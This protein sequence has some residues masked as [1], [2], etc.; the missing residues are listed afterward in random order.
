MSL[1]K[2]ILSCALLVG[3]VLVSPTFAKESQ[4]DSF[5]Q[6]QLNHFENKVRPILVRRCNECHANGESEGG[7]SLR[8]RSA[9]IAGGDT[10]AA[11]V[12]GKPEA[13]L[14]VKAIHYDDV[15]E[16]P[17]ESKMP[18]EEIKILED[19]IRDSAPWPE[20]SGEHAAAAKESFDIEGR[21][22]AHW[23]W[24]PVV[25]PSLPDRVAGSAAVDWLLDRKLKAKGLESNGPTKRSSLLRRIS[26]DLTGLPPSPKQ[27]QQFAIDES[28]TKEQL[29][30]QLL[31]SPHFGE[32]WARHWMDLARY[33]ET[34]GHEFDYPINDAWQYRDYLIRAFNTDVPY[35]QFVTEHIAG[36]LVENPR[37]NPDS[38]FNESV[39]AT[40][41][42][43]LGEATHG[44]V[45][46]KEDEAKR[47]DN[48]IDVMCRSFIGL[49]VA[50]ARCHDH[51]FDAISTKDYYA[52]S[53]YLQSSR[54]QR[55]V[56]DKGRELEKA[57]NEVGKIREQIESAT[58]SLINKMAASENPDIANKLASID[59]PRLRVQPK[60]SWPNPTDEKADVE[61]PLRA[62]HWKTDGFA[63]ANSE[64]LSSD[65]N[66]MG[67]SGVAHSS[68]FEIKHKFI[69]IRLKSKKAFVQ[70]VVDGYRMH[71]FNAILFK[72]LIH[73]DVN[74]DDYQWLTIGKEL[75][76]HLGNR[77]WLEFED[78]GDGFFAIDRVVF[79]NREKPPQ[80]T[81]Q[82]FDP[83][84]FTELAQ[85]PHGN[86]I[87]SWILKHKL[88][89][90]FD[91]EKEA[92]QIRAL[93]QQVV[94]INEKLPATSRAITMTEGFPEDEF[95]FVR[96]NHKMTGE[97]A[98]RRF[99]SA[100]V[101]EDR[102]LDRD[103]GSGRLQL[104]R[105]LLDDSN[106]LASRVIVNRVWHHLFGRGIVRSVDNFGV[107]G[108]EP[109][110]PELLDHLADEFVKD[111]WSIKRLIRKLMLTEVYARSS[112][113]SSSASLDDPQN[114][115]LSRANVRRLQGEAIRD[116]ILVASGRLDR[117]MFGPSVP[118]HITPFM[119][120]RGRPGKSGEL[121]SNG[122]RSLYIATR[123]NFLSPMMLAFDTPIPF[124]AIGLR[125][126]S[127]VPAQALILMNDPLVL[128]QSERFAKRV[129]EQQKEI[130][131]RI[132]FVYLT[133]L[134]RKPDEGELQKSRS[135]IES[136]AKRLDLDID[137]EKV[138]AD[139]CHVVFNVKEFIWLN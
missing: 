41:F 88:E 1:F 86:E 17:P 14:L 13:S 131:K 61:F 30:D 118:I 134:S 79:S 9:M 105:K 55:E 28:I 92:G 43:F 39:L 32:R 120:G 99:L 136:H 48:Q 49:T 124:N 2:K 91:A 111:G 94:A 11:I 7:L 114:I 40:G 128:Q 4:E 121:D 64:N 60:A 89:G 93:N 63:F 122:R 44:P 132:E 112:S 113:P 65:S 59:A 73:K 42:W 104:A 78:S 26:F 96:G 6:Q 116:S 36:D 38:D 12:P 127:N 50:C 16:M 37:R 138:W 3:N 135:F 51:K 15:Y 22:N 33:A 98:P 102:S 133:A 25:A 83:N 66:G 62:E 57:A 45:D 82:D 52:L 123:R 139:F 81:K 90:L 54:R 10:G 35:D 47:V 85:G 109:S 29:I 20:L 24:K 80:D 75:Y 125:S 77:A 115:L 106:P 107:L 101:G 5:T 103:Q 69:H 76:L 31:D 56:I 71:E 46:S 130:E 23:C 74:H 117:K 110:H 58:N 53:G 126:V 95:V 27:V 18:D 84:K 72:G 19:W 97:L 100:I 108:E 21:K 70:L 87:A 129:L 34:Y 119:T 137:S 68:T 8:S 67:F